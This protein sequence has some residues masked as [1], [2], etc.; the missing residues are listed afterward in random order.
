MKNSESLV[1]SES[2]KRNGPYRCFVFSDGIRGKN[3]WSVNV[4]ARMDLGA[5][6]P[7][8]MFDFLRDMDQQDAVDYQNMDYLI[9]D[10]NLEINLYR[11]GTGLCPPH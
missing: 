4:G 3:F 6:V 9:K 11:A 10:E 2:D 5:E 7:K 8:S 1:G